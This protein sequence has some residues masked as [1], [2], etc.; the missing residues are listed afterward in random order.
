MNTP[1]PMATNSRRR[2]GLLAREIREQFLGHEPGPDESESD[3]RVMLYSHD[4]M[5]MGHMRRN[6]L[7][8]GSI[9]VRFPGASILTVAGAKEACTFAQQAGLDCLTLPSFQKRLDGTYTSRSL[10]IPAEEVLDFRNRMILTAM[11]S[12][13]PDLLIVDK[14]PAGAGGE[15]LPALEWITR[16]S[17][18]R[19]VLGLRDILDAPEKVARDWSCTHTFETIR[20]HFQEIWIYGDP[21]VYDAIHQYA[22]P[23]DIAALAK[24]TG[25]LDTRSRLNDSISRPTFDADSYVLCTVGGGQDG[26]ALPLGFIEAI[27]MTGRKAKL[28]LGPYMPSAMKEQIL[29]NS[30]NVPSLQVIEFAIEGDL[31]ARDASHVVSMG[32]YNTLAA[33]LSWNK[34]ALIVPRVTPRKEQSIRASRLAELGHIDMIL[35][36]FLTSDAIVQW[37]HKSTSRPATSNSLDMNGLQRICESIHASFPTVKFTSN[38]VAA[39]LA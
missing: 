36:E 1:I 10:G 3:L 34:P 33:I 14:L 12:F 37:L 4:T 15:L 31:L 29:L 25:Y 17:S 2:F 21:N 26:E 11:K 35:P 5:G 39:V 18:C 38:G 22:F 9:K 7:I 19:C 16:H 13:H 32:G 6:L 28:L 23:D 8:A 24:F 20:D 27:R 30:A